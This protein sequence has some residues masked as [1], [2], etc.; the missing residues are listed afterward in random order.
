M[1]PI[2]L[3]EVVTISVYADINVWLSPLYLHWY[4]DDI[5]RELQ[6]NNNT[7]LKFK[8]HFDL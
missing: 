2:I 1:T 3:P 6:L 7:A 8:Q 5:T 4:W